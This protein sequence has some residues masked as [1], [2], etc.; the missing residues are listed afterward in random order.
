MESK[1]PYETPLVKGFEVEL[2]QGIAAASVNESSLNQSW[3]DS[4]STHDVE[5]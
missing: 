3:E 4:A 1:K 2:E 5:W